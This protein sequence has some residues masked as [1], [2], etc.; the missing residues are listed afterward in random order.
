MMTAAMNT[1]KKLF[2]GLILLSCLPAFAAKS[3]SAD[4]LAPGFS[5]PGL[6]GEEIHLA[7][8]QGKLVVL[9]F[10]ATFCYPCRAEMPSLQALA[11]QY[12]HKDVVVIAVSLDDDG[13]TKAIK[14]W[15]EKTGLEFPI[16]LEGDS[17]SRDYKVSALP[18]TYLINRQ[19]QLVKR[20]LGE[21]DWSSDET[22]NLIDNL[23]AEQP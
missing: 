21:R 19:G 23:I 3:S 22:Q 20:I 17:I 12:A 1:A 11:E 9:N 2:A 7:D 8:Y 10:W 15:V 5:L 18:V 4:L 14:K 13:R 6:N 16:A